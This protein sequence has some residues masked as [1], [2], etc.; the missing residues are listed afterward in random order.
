MDLLMQ[1]WMLAVVIAALIV[2]IFL[3]LGKYYFMRRH[4]YLN[5]VRDL[6]LH[7]DNYRLY[8][9]VLGIS[10][11]ATEIFMEIFK[12]RAESQLLSNLVF[13]IF[14]IALFYGS[15]SVELLKK[16]MH[17]I[18]LGF[19]IIYSGFIYYNM[20]RLPADLPTV[21]EFTLVMMFANYAFYTIRFY[22]MYV[23]ASFVALLSMH[24]SGMIDLN[25]LVLNYNIILVAIALNYAKYAIDLNIRKNLYWAYNV[26]NN[27][28]LLV[29]GIDRKG[30]ISF[31][32]ENVK[33][34]L[35]YSQVEIIGME[36]SGRLADPSDLQQFIEKPST[37]P[38]LQKVITKTGTDRLIEWQDD[39]VYADLTIKVGRDVTAVKDA[40]AGLR[41]T[42]DRLHVL[43]TSSGEFV[44]VLD[45]NLVFTEYY[46]YDKSIEDIS[47][48]VSF[49]I[50][51]HISD[52]DYSADS[53]A[54]FSDAIAQALTTRGIAYTEVW[55]LFGEQKKWFSIAI[56]T[57][58][59]EQGEA[60][61]IICIAR[62]IT[63]RKQ[64]EA[65]LI[66]NQQELLYKSEMLA[67]IA[68][69]TEKILI[70]KNIYE[71]LTETFPIIGQAIQ[72]DRVYFFENDPQ[73]HQVSQKIEWTNAT[74][75]A[76]INNPYLQNMPYA[77][78]GNYLVPILQN[79]PVHSIVS[80]LEDSTIRQ[81]LQAKNILSLL[82]LP[83]FIK[84]NF[85]G[86]I[87]F[88]DCKMMRIWSADELNILQSL[89]TNI[90]NGIERVNNERIIQENE[91]N[92]R[93]INDTIEDVFWLYDTLH[94]KYIYMSPSC[95]KLLGVDQTYFYNQ[96][97]YL[98][99]YVLAENAEKA[100]YLAGLFSQKTP[101][102]VEYKIKTPDGQI[103]WIYEKSFSIKNDAGELIRVSGICSDITEKKEA[104]IARE[105]HQKVLALQKRI[106]TQISTTPFEQ[107]LSLQICLQA[108]NKAAAQ[109]LRVDRVSIWDYTGVSL[110]CRDL[111][112]LKTDRHSNGAILLARDFPAY[113][114]GIQTGLAI[115][116]VDARTNEHTFEFADTYLTPLHITAMLDVPVRIGGKLVGVVCCEHTGDLPKKWTEDDLFFARSIAD[117]V[118]LALEAD[119]RQQ[120][121]IELKKSQRAY[122]ELV[123]TIPVGV[124][125]F[126]RF[127]DGTNQLLYVSP[128]LCEMTGLPEAD[129]L[130]IFKTP[131]KIIS[132]EDIS[133]FIYH[134]EEVVKFRNIFEWEGKILLRNE[135]RVVHL[136][137]FPQ[138]S[139][140][141]TLIWNGIMYDITDRKRAETELLVTKERLESL[142]ESIPD[143]IFFKDG[144]GKWLI[145]NEVAR[146]IFHL[147]NFDWLG[148]TDRQMTLTNPTL[149]DEYEICLINDEKT[150][151]NGKLSIFT[152]YFK[153][154]NGMICENEVR[155]MPVFYK[156]GTRKAMVII[157]TDVTERRAVERELLQAKQQAEAA[158]RAKSEFLANMS[159]ELRTPLNGVIGFSDLLMK[160]RLDVTQQEFMSLVYRSANSLLEVINDILDFSK[161]E[162]G[163]LELAIEKTELP[164]I[165]SQVLDVITYQAQ[166]KKLAVRLTIDPTVPRY[167]WADGI[168]LK[169]VLIN[170][171][172]NA[173]KFTATGEI[174]L[175]VQTLSAP[176]PLQTR[177]RFSVKDT[178]I[179]IKL[180][181][182]QKI[183]EAFAQEDTSTTRRFGGTGLGLTISNKLLGLMGSELHLQSEPDKGSTFYFDAT[184]KPAPAQVLTGAI[185]TNPVAA[186]LPLHP[187]S[188]DLH[189]RVDD[190]TILIAEDNAANMFLAKAIF[191]NILPSAIIVEATNGLE[192]IDHYKRQLPDLIFMDIQ[193]PEMNGHAAAV[194]IR[195][196]ETD[197]RIPIIALTAGTAKDEKEKCFEAGMD[198]YISKPILP[199]TIEQVIKKWLFAPPQTPL[200]PI[201]MKATTD[202]HFD[203]TEFQ[204]RVGNNKETMH[205][206]LLLI[207]EYLD[208][209][210]QE[211]QQHIREK[212]LSAIKAAG[213]SL[214]GTALSACLGTL[215]Q[216]AL[217]LEQLDAF[218]A[219]A[220][221][222]LFQD[223]H[224]EI[225]IVKSLIVQQT[226]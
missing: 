81:V 96:P 118:S 130:R 76:E 111:Y 210:P 86:F 29:I 58:Y 101:Y 208:T 43:L 69:A 70:S 156:D 121:E 24:L 167:V 61:E 109:G 222:A 107:Y 77:A 10:F 102:A 72:A 132:S 60:N 213:H 170:L 155:K 6:A 122:E 197:R 117:I 97:N 119:K 22:F 159:H 47:R 128:R 104:E 223:I 64:I 95:E 15:R 154:E 146:K 152:E 178:G 66:A 1:N 188:N 28:T 184:F 20:S 133:F 78:F 32:S 67:A 120:A 180:E 193:M 100:T 19:Y 173:V 201:T 175:K 203:V 217:Q 59:N 103:K 45:R 4:T 145:T 106:L 202:A 216:Q 63:A 131:T 142:V 136:E 80:E 36:W 171:L 185:S 8:F 49:F 200:A 108:I 157:G 91:N 225:E 143:A 75:S 169:Q 42:N 3:L 153:D 17:R 187:G 198:D 186:N 35:G 139:E 110:I 124:F 48:P 18:F 163:L 192:A 172:S 68:K 37:Q 16:N 53:V 138:T 123:A 112:E 55:R 161:I 14:C 115:V 90:A 179:G 160:T 41:Q 31:V 191:R 30:K 113:F 85:C 199:H 126:A 148:Q 26:V 84:N 134:L 168:R 116:A 52:I 105:Q 207:G 149:A 34:I 13:G 218:E 56:S 87:G 89:A 144:G 125:K 190:V 204:R 21:V 2:A 135:T 214:K 23:L 46:N 209:F 224:T 57:P 73:T 226:R 220:V 9:L 39:A 140:G 176:A 147:H 79:K 40:E 211:L 164:A 83:I 195:Q 98:Q 215:S 212:N 114:K 206:L 183:F 221:H 65:T 93:Q 165:G 12:V 99:D 177:L 11:P 44:F 50:G 150:W 127:P 194:A 51:K 33:S 5:N 92:F 137:A 151:A 219:V 82:L 129:L 74:V 166:Q 196:L 25:F 162:S 174:E 88:D 7:P 27:G 38:V 182:Q 181:N 62:N 189:T 54:L 71:S 205:G 141:E 94:Q 158:N